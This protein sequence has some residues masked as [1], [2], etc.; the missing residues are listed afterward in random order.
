AG[1]TSDGLGG[2][3]WS[4]DK[5]CKGTFQGSQVYG[6]ASWYNDKFAIMYTWYFPK[7]SWAV[8]STHRHDWSSLV[9]W[10]D[11]PEL[12]TPTMLGLSFSKTDTKYD[13]QA[14]LL[15]GNS[16]TTPTILRST[17]VFSGPPYLSETIIQGDFQ[18]LIM[19]DQLTDAARKALNT[20]D[21]GSAKVPF[22]DENFQKKLEQAWPFER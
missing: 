11:N 9:V 13:K 8:W 12:E 2:A 18:D 19:W 5:A 22:I 4:S 17:Q 3:I 16:I 20:T 21:F 7:S 1:E 15:P 10:I 14:P 6:R